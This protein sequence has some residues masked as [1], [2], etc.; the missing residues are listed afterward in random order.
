MDKNL[1]IHFTKEDIQIA[2][3]CM[4]KCLTS[5]AIRKSYIKLAMMYHCIHFRKM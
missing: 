3:K 5:Y 2:S 1:K 4:K